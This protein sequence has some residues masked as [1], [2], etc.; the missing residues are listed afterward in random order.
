M[1]DNGKKKVPRTLFSLGRA[2]G[3]DDSGESGSPPPPPG[4]SGAAETV[5]IDRS[6]L[7]TGSCP[8]CG[9][10]M[11]GGARFCGECGARL[12]DTAVS[13]EDEEV[14]VEEVEGDDVEGDEEYEYEYVEEE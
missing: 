14:V 6:A 12:E 10:A 2:S 3:R 9:A 13:Y 7:D 1:A 11:P 5:Q 4:G 8:S